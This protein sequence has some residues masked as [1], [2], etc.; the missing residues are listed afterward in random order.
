MTKYLLP[1]FIIVLAGCGSPEGPEENE[2]TITGEAQGTTYMVKYHGNDT[3]FVAEIENL[4]DLFDRDLS[5]WR[6]GSLINRI[7]DHQRRDTVF[8]FVDSTKYFS[9]VFDLSRD[10]Y[11]KT[12]GAFD[13]SVY[14][15]VQA[16][17]FGLKNKDE[18]TPELIDSLLGCVGFTE[19]DIDMIEQYEREY[20][21]KETQIWKGNP[22]VKL[23]F[24]AIAQGYSV[25]LVADLLQEH[26]VF[27]YMV[28]IG[29][30]V[31]CKGLNAKGELW[32]IAIDKPV[33]DEEEREFQAVLSVAD[34]AV[35]TSGSYRKFY[36]ENGKKYSHT[37]DP[38]SGFPVDHNLLSATV[39]ANSCASADAFATAFMVM[40]IEGTL[41]FLQE[42]PDL[43]LE[44]YLIFEDEGQ[45]QT[46]TSEG[47][48]NLIEEIP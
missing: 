40:G 2:I 8:S 7:N 12:Q 35:A 9:V 19:F 31:A 16:W 33:S 24:N 38:H 1:I 23:D 30:E 26:E 4:L 13:P 11:L 39:M 3:N 37:I 27:N 6:E 46:L 45:L 18:I 20:F 41:Q 22:K 43:G 17:G 42:Y 21:Y 15:L 29:G 48:L 44:V 32:K 28:E 34:K 36:V 10:I 25:D 47:L 14:P 5:N